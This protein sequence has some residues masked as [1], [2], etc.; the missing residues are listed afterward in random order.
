MNKNDLIKINDYIWEIPQS[1]RSDMN[2]PARIFVS[3]EMLDDLFRD[4]SLWQLV[5]LTTLPGIHKYAIVMPDVHEGYGSPIG[6]VAAF[7]YENGIIS[8][9]ICGFDINCGVRLLAS[10]FYY[11]EIKDKMPKLT[12]E[13]FKNVPS[14]VGRGGFLRLNKNEMKK[15]LE[16]G[17][18]YLVDLGYGEKEDLL[19][20]ESFGFIEGADSDT[21]SSVAKKRGEDQLGTLGAG[22]HFLEIQR[23]SEV[24]DE[25]IAK[26]L[27][28]E[29]NKVCI[30][31]HCGSRGLGHQVASDYIREFIR[32]CDNKNIKLV[33]RE[34][35]YA[36]IDSDLGKRY[37]SAM[38][39]SANFAWANRQLIANQIRKVFRKIFGD[40]V[41][42]NQIY[43]VAHNIVKIEEYTDYNGLHTDYNGLYTDYNGLHTDYTDRINKK[44]IYEDL[45]YKII[46]SALKVKKILGLGQK[47]IVYKNALEKEFKERNL[48]FEREKQIEI[49]YEGQIVG[50]YKPDFII[51]NKI[52][53]EIKSLDSIN[54]STLKQAWYYLKNTNY[55]LALILNFSKN[56]LEIKRILNVKDKNILDVKDITLS[57]QSVLSPKKSVKLI[58]HRKGAT[59]AFWRGH[60]ELPE[61]YRDI[62]Q[63]VIIP[64]SMGTESYLLIGQELAGDLSFGSAPHGSG[65][66]MSRAEAI[67]KISG[68]ELKKELESK[69]IVIFVGS[70]KGLSEEAPSAYKNVKD[71]VDVVHNMGIAKKIIKLTP[72]GVVK[73]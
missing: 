46:G 72:L 70:I 50:Y 20:T 44:L 71:V 35:A 28:L 7:K 56:G 36:P 62:G 11:E 37:F 55:L 18:K 59:R 58:I 64:G 13:I 23:V 40:D 65:R 17:A 67:R 25:D 47:E 4:K 73:G 69:G 60:E 22:N 19:A 32:Y 31:I 15:V 8:P 57:E 27:G 51:E 49:K 2:V 5:N 53:I 12:E 1:Y 39:C 68:S 45:T 26:K 10:P 38:K 9:G 3:E 30:L 54:K 52:V 63:P 29:K 61:K 16:E 14:G 48:N 41:K 33:D 43:D 24:Y 42:L 21:V 34:L 66:T 6:A